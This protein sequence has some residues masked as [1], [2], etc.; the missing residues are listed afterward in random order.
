[1][2]NE[3]KQQ[4]PKMKFK[5]DKEYSFGYQVIWFWSGGYF[6]QNGYDAYENEVEGAFYKSRQDAELEAMNLEWEGE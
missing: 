6:S 2:I 1:M 5:Q 3:Y 4:G